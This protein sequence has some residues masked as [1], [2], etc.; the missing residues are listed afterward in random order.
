MDISFG[1]KR[2][3]LNICNASLGSPI[4]DYGKVNM[5]EEIEEEATP[6][7]LLQDSLY[8][9]LAHFRIDDFD[10]NGYIEEVNVLLEPPTSSTTLP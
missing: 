3:R 5:L 9:C 6:T 10:V 4:D 8:V 7:I 2:L 1:N